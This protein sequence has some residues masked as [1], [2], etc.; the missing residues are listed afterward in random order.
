MSDWW[1]DAFDNDGDREP[2][3]HYGDDDI[4]QQPEAE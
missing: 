1:Q 2:D 4:P 3:K